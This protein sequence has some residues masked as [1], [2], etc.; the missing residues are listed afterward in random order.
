MKEYPFVSFHSRGQSGNIFWILGAAKGVMHKQR[1]IT[2]FND[3][4]EAVQK[5]GSY[6]E[7]LQ[8][9]GQHVLLRDED[10]GREWGA[11]LYR[12]WKK[13]HREPL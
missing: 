1:R 3:M 6:D 9:I 7:A 12:R 5:S 8:I 10:T 11:D 2:E 13:N 4:W